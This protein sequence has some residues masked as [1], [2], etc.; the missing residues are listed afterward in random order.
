[1]HSCWV[2]TI[3]GNLKHRKHSHAET[4]PRF[5]SELDHDFV[6]GKAPAD[7]QYQKHVED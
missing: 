4:D 1:M 7:Q 6:A 5:D 2:G 3:H